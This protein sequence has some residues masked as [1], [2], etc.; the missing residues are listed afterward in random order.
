MSLWTL[1]DGTLSCGSCATPIAS[2]QPAR[3]LR[4]GTSV[5]CASCAE[6]MFDEQPPDTL[7]SEGLH[8]PSSWATARDIRDRVQ[9]R[10]ALL[11]LVRQGTREAS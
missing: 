7:V 9:T 4:I 5:R 10:G 6:R 8:G 2:G 11:K 3:R 1:S